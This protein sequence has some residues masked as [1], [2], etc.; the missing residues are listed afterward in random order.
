M[1]TIIFTILIILG[2]VLPPVWFRRGNILGTVDQFEEMETVDL[3]RLKRR[4][5]DIEK[6]SSPF[7]P[8]LPIISF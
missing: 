1:N 2:V 6:K 4:L 7:V 5:L 8:A 3:D